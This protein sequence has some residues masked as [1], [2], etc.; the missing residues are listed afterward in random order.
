MTDPDSGQPR[1]RHLSGQVVEKCYLC[2][3]IKKQEVML[4]QSHFL[5][6]EGLSDLLSV[7]TYGNYW[8]ILKIKRS[9]YHLAE[10]DKHDC[11]EDKWAAILINGGTLVVYDDYEMGEL[12]ENELPTKYALDLKGVRRGL[13]LMKKNYPD[14]YADLVTGQDDLNT[15]D[16]WLQLAVFGEVIYG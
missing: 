1:L 4:T 12:D 13:R 10:E 8:P 6:H 16:I 11:L 7:A 14:D 2:N 9:E 3:V 15:G 5:T